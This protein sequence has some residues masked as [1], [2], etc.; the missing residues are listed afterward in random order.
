MRSLLGLAVGAVAGWF[1][2]VLPWLVDGGRLQISSAWSSIEPDETPWVALPFGEYALGLL[3]VAGGIGGAAG[4]VV[5]RLLRIGHHAGAI[6]ALAGFAGALAQT[7]GVVG[8]FREETD[9][10]LLLVIVLVAAALT[11]PVFGVLAGLGIASGRRWSQVAGGM[12]VAALLPSW[13]AALVLA[14]GLDSLAHRAHWIIAPALAVV[15]VRAGVRPAWH[16]LG[17]VVPV[18]VATFAQ[19]FFTAL[20]YAAVYGSSGMGSGEGLREL[21]DS[22]FDVFT[23]ASHP[24]TYL[25]APPAVAVAAALTWSTAQTLS[26]R[27]HREP[28]PVTE[29][30]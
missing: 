25:L 17:W 27:D 16:L 1:V 14:A 4:V 15:L 7:W 8:P 5:P 12:V 23:A 18:A 11:A 21:I 10:A 3:I 22:T 19:P 30:G 29:R 13:A 20:S 6:G 24:S 28:D 2:G 9:A 26:G